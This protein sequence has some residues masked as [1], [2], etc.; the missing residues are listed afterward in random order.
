MRKK[1]KRDISTNY[2]SFLYLIVFRVYI[3][4][5][6]EVVFNEIFGKMIVR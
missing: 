4:L 3:A 2:V 5:L 1:L 6:S